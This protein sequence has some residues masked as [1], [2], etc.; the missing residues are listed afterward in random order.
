MADVP[1][2]FGVSVMDASVT[3]IASVAGP[4]FESGDLTSAG[5]QLFATLTLMP[6]PATDMLAVVDLA[7]MS[8]QILGDTQEN[9]VWGLA[10]LGG[11]IYGLTC[12]GHVLTIDPKT[13][14][15]TQVGS[16]SPA[17]QGAAGR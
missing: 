8:T 4:Y 15:S 7:S 1:I 6:P 12:K 13:G 17:F 14:A 10:T 3:P 11:V 2:V 9:C 16:A 5:G